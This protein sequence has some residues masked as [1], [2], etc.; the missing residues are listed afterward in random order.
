[1]ARFQKKHTATPV[2]DVAVTENESATIS[3]WEQVESIKQ[4]MDEFHAAVVSAERA[5]SHTGMFFG[6]DKDTTYSYGA[7]DVAKLGKLVEAVGAFRNA[8]KDI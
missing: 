3:I 6:G 5:A 8:L 2:V 7:G 4:S 1:M